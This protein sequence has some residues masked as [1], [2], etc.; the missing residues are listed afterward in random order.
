MAGLQRAHSV[1]QERRGGAARQNEQK[2]VKL[3]RTLFRDGKLIISGLFL[4]LLVL[5]AVFA[6]F[7]APKDPNATDYRN[8]FAPMSR[9]AL[10]GTDEFGRDILSR[11]IYGAR[12]S[13]TVAVGSIAIAAFFG[14]GMGVL[15]AYYRGW[16]EVLCMRFIDLLLIFPPI[17]LAIAVVAF[18]GSGM[19]HL[20]FV[21]GVLYI[22]RFARVAYGTASSLREE[23][24]IEAARAL[25]A[26]DGRIIVRHILPNMLSPLI[27]QGAFSMAFVILLESGLN[28]LG[29][30]VPPSTPSW[31]LMIG[32][33]RNYMRISENVLLWPALA[34]AVT[35][36]AVNL[37]ADGLQKRLNPE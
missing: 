29:L 20:I 9:D 7:I 11:I 10:L 4:I 13:L 34:V 27:V 31:G 19:I 26:S 18:L 25:G 16:V 17:F 22:P 1:W 14:V 2:P 33:A 37:F 5:T 35:I 23:A 6:P 21:I 30:G 36:L 28:F 12:V 24:F 3:M 32:T 15:S 8:R